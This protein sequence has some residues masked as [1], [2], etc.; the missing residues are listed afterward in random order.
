MAYTDESKALI[1]AARK[2]YDALTDDQ[3]ALVTAE[4]LK[5][6][7]DAEAKYAELKKAADDFI[8]LTPQNL[9]VAKEDKDGDVEITL[10]WDKVEG[11]ISYELK[12]SIG[13]KELFSQ[14]TMTLNVI[15]RQLSA[16]EKEYK[17]TPGTYTIDWS[18]RSTD[19]LGI[20]MSDW[21]KGPSFEVTVKD[22]ATGVDEI[23]N[24]K[25]S[26]R[27]LIIDGVLYIEHNGKILDATGR[28]VK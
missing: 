17:L 7:T 22:P 6:L 28:L 3:K 1:D 16:L 4:K 9:Q 8:A 26:N 20:P 24:R 2:A 27:K 14:N 5:V 10:S 23:V 19:A 18:V 11:A 21:A 25:S 12:M 15:S 13:E